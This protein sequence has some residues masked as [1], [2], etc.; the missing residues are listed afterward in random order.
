MAL[1]PVARRLVPED[2]FDQLLG[3]V[4]DGEL[5]AGDSLPRERRLAQ[6]LGVSRPPGREGPPRPP[7]PPYAGPSSGPPRRGSSRSA[8]A[9][10]RPCATIAPP[11]GWTSSP[12]CWC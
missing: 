4:V 5:S 3:E 7:A 10:A 12:G 11:P 6:V 2:V 8:T 9:A 1:K